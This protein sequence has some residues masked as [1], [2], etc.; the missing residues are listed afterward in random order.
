KNVSIIEFV[1]K[2]SLMSNVW[3]L[4]KKILEYKHSKIQYAISSVNDPSIVAPD[5]QKI[6][7]ELQKELV[8]SLKYLNKNEQLVIS[9][10]YEEELTFT[11]IGQV[12]DL[13]TSR[14]SQI[15]KKAIF[16]LRNS[17]KKIQAMA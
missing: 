6:R 5:Q 17:L 13:T 10:F 15:H 12:L 2:D 16:K 9:L 14:I 3:S 4:E 8:E 7:R 11:E 1:D